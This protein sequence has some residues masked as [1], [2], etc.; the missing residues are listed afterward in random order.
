LPWKLSAQAP[1]LRLSPQAKQGLKTEFNGVA[2]G[3]QAS[4]AK[5]LPHQFIV[6]DNV[7]TH[8]VYSSKNLYTL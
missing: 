3:F 7:R 5:R 2:F 4:H 6:D 1:D 8:D